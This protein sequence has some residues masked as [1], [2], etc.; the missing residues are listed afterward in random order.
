M[1]LHCVLALPLS[2]SFPNIMY[3]NVLS[4]DFLHHSV[5]FQ[6]GFSRTL[7]F[8]GGSGPAH[9][10]LVL[11]NHVLYYYAACSDCLINV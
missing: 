1:L 10:S 9:R 3:D 11:I 5:S 4:V 2:L 7:A 8:D 6:E